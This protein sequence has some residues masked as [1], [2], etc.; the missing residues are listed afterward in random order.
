M[1]LLIYDHNKTIN[2]YRERK[3]TPDP[4]LNL[5]ENGWFSLKKPL[6][7]FIDQNVSM[8]AFKFYIS[9]IHFSSTVVSLVV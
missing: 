3:K 5:I 7:I 6:L 2:F 9:Q 8:D 1:N 4:G